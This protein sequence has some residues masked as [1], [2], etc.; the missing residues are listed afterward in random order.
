MNL[1]CAFI[2]DTIE[3]DLHSVYFD[4]C[5]SDQ[6]IVVIQRSEELCSPKRKCNQVNKV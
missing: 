4:S 3:V 1:Y 2:P 6:G 5:K